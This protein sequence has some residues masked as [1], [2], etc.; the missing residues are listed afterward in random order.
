MQQLV[1]LLP[2][3]DTLDSFVVH[4]LGHFF[5]PFLLLLFGSALFDSLDVSLGG[6][7]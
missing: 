5:V 4:F 1:A 7:R 3:L 2:P 6:G